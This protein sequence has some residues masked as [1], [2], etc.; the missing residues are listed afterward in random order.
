MGQ[1]PQYSERPRLQ[2]MDTGNIIPVR[3]YGP[4]PDS[5][6]GVGGHPIIRELRTLQPAIFNAGQGIVPASVGGS[7]NQTYEG[8]FLESLAAPPSK[9]GSI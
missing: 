9:T 1:L 3:P 8:I 7:T 5:V 6:Y 4:A 2:E